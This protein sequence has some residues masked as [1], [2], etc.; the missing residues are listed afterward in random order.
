[1]AAPRH[2]PPDPA[3]RG[4]HPGAGRAGAARRPRVRA[5]PGSSRASAASSSPAGPTA[6]P[7]PTRR[8]PAARAGAGPPRRR[9]D[10][11][12]TARRPAADAATP[13]RSATD[14]GT[15]DGTADAAQ[16]WVFPF[17]K[18]LA[19]GEG[20]NQAM[21]VNT[22]D[23]TIQ[24]DVAFALVWVEDDSPA[25]NTNEAYA[26]ASCTNCAAV[27][28]RLPDRPG[29]RRQPRRGAAEHLGRGQL[30]LR[31]LPDLRPRDPAV[32][33]PRRAAQ[34]RGHAADR[35]AVAA[36]RR[37]R[38]AHHRGA[39][40]RDPGPADRLR[41]ADPG[42]HREGAG[43]ADAGPHGRRRPG[44]TPTA[45]VREQRRR[46]HRRRQPSPGA[47]DA[48]PTQ[49]RY[50]RDGRH[51]R[52]R[53]HG[54]RDGRRDRPPHGPVPDPDGRADRTGS[55]TERDPARRRRPRSSELRHRPAVA[56]VPCSTAGRWGP[57]TRSG[58]WPT[59]PR[60]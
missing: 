38:H 1:M 60:P 7:R 47:G 11:D 22:T 2:L 12:R 20:D 58:R 9:R 25:L 59:A 23:D 45:A 54:R 8:Q 51:R 46:G 36:D 52:R 17:N 18:P 28:G 27:V 3:L 41:A 44:A 43:P 6:T 26:F 57:S 14:A 4:R 21:A 49:R 29:H 33:D 24:Y 39:A 42:G 35:R 5:A 50:A 40:L 13:H 15:G 31:Q 56:T 34:R 30:R 19:P 16:P 53:Q 10:G 55:L 37:L 32:R 48:R